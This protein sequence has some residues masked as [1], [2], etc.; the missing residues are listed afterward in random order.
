LIDQTLFANINPVS[1]L[2]DSVL[3]LVY[4]QACA[5]CGASV[6]SRHD[7]VACAACWTGTRLFNDDDTVCWKCGAVS[8]ASVARDKRR[9]VRCGKCDDD[10]FTFARACG[11]YEGA[12]R[13]SVLALKREPQVAR[14][15][16]NVL[17]QA[18]RGT[19]INDADVIVPVPLHAAR[20]RARGFNQAALLAQE[21]GRLSHL[22]VDEHS[23]VR[24][25]HTERHRAGMDARAR[26]DSVAKA[27]EVRH[28]KLISGRCVLLVDDVFTT[29]ATVSACATALKNAGATDVYV[30]TIARA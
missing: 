29:G 13:A 15:L 10:Q 23:V 22:P 5:A 14:R 24:S 25:V 9:T 4:P 27:F 28:P 3:A 1:G 17:Y 30:L 2:Y 18:Q 8:R 21:L 12:L 20:E 19:P 16:S 7:G 26:R 11:L 6:E